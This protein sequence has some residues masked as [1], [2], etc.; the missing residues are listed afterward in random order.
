[1]GRDTNDLEI[2]IKTKD[3]IDYTFKIREGKKFPKKARFVF[4]NR[5]Q[6]LAL[7]IYEE[8]LIIN[9]IEIKDRIPKLIN[10]LANIKIMLFLTVRSRILHLVEDGD[11]L[12]TL[13]YIS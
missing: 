13:T 6:N 7:N 1:M 8:L 11:E 2:F 10:V 9:E 3:L 5:I 4:V 12:C